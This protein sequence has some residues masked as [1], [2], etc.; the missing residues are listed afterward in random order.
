MQRSSHG[1]QTEIR[2]AFEK[3]Q[4][5]HHREIAGEKPKKKRTTVFGMV[6]EWKHHRPIIPSPAG[7]GQSFFRTTV[8]E[9][10]PSVKAVGFTKIVDEMGQNG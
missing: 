9:G 7:V 6:S 3:E 4:E 2:K 5:R 1:R 10:E 8:K